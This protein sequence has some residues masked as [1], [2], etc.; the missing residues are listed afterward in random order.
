MGENQSKEEFVKQVVDDAGE[1]QEAAGE[2][3]SS[4]SP[5][6]KLLNLLKLKDQTDKG[7]S[8]NEHLSQNSVAS[9]TTDEVDSELEIIE[10]EDL[11][12]GKPKEENLNIQNEESEETGSLSAES[13]KEDTYKVEPRKSLTL[14]EIIQTGNE[15]EFEGSTVKPKIAEALGNRSWASEWKVAS[16]TEV[17]SEPSPMLL[18]FVKSDDFTNKT[19]LH[20]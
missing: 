5:I 13:E 19:R 1:K 2:T 7:N 18:N 12:T 3:Q 15:T 4:P 11:E 10:F 20:G 8:S 14:L 9:E 16:K 17:T 6:P